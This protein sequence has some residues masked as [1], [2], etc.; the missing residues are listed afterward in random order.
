MFDTFKAVVVSL[1]ASLLTVVVFTIFAE[2]YFR[3]TVPFNKNYWPSQFSPNVG[4]TLLPGATLKHTNGTDYWQEHKINS[5]GFLDREPPNKSKKPNECRV[6]IIG[7]SFVEAVQVPLAK[8]FQVILENNLEQQHPD[9]DFTTLALGYSGTGQSNQ[10]AFYDHFAKNYEIDLL[11]LVFVENDFANNSSILEAIRRNHHPEHQPRYF[12]VRDPATG[13]FRG[14]DISPDF[15]G[16]H[17]VKNKQTRPKAR[18][19]T[20]HTWLMQH[21]YFYLWLH[22]HL[23]IDFPAVANLLSGTEKNA[24]HRTPWRERMEALEKIEGFENVFSGWRFPDDLN[25][26]MIFLAEKLPGVFE[27]AIG[28]TEAS[29]SAFKERAINDGFSL[30]V[31]SGYGVKNM[32]VNNNYDRELLENG[33]F[34]R[35]AE[36]LDRLNIPL[37]DQYDYIKSGGGEMM[38]ARFARDAHWSETGHRWAAEAVTAFLGNDVSFCES[39]QK[40]D[41]R[42][43]R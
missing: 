7:D 34:H 39:L 31:L 17:L 8:K 20:T 13:Y 15:R 19:E 27:D 30:L 33:Y 22:K 40:A 37:I 42:V 16:F 36:I 9:I 35:L 12:F 41:D 43:K 25:E 21:S 5:I 3:L 11:I 2:G 24:D 4:H 23:A 10:L 38:N 28:A 26:N 1:L 14:K 32:R 29:F 18:R 6:A